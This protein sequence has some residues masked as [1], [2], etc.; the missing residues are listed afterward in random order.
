MCPKRWTKLF[1]RILLHNTND[2][3]VVEITATAGVQCSYMDDDIIFVSWMNEE[4]KIEQ[5][6]RKWKELNE[7]IAPSNAVLLFVKFRWNFL[8]WCGDTN[9]SLVKLTIYMNL[10]NF[11]DLKWVQRHL[12]IDS[13]FI[14]LMIVPIV[15]MITNNLCCSRE[16]CFPPHPFVCVFRKQT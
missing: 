14:S 2:T 8:L 4:I 7:L 10:H 3:V 6:I 9:R 12:W 13:S 11:H 15:R 5:I 1:K 16:T